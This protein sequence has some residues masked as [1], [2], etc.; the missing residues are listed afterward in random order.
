MS[1]MDGHLR[2]DGSLMAIMDGQS[3]MVNATVEIDDI[4]MTK[5][6]TSW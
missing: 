5:Q 1:I 4:A 2:R 3:P 6:V